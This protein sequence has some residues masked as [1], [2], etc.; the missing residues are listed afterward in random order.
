MKAHEE[1][2]IQGIKTN[3][4]KNIDVVLK[5]RSIN[6]VV[7]PSGSGK[8]SLAFDTIGGIGQHEMTSMF[9][10]EVAEP[11]YRVRS[12]RNMIAAVPIPQLNNNNNIRST[13]GTYFG[14]NRS[15][16]LLYSALLHLDEDFFVLNREQNVCPQCRGLGI[17]LQ[18]DANRVINYDTP[19]EACPIKCW[20]R[21]RDFYSQILRLFCVDQ[22]IDFKKTFRMLNDNE[23]RTIL[24]GQSEEKYSVRYKRA[25]IFST[26]S[27]HYY[28]VM[29]GKPML[30]KFAPARQFFADQPCQSCKGRK[31]SQEHE[32]FKLYELSIGEFMCTPFSDLNSWIEAVSRDAS[33]SNLSFAASHIARFVRTAVEMDLGHLFFHRSIPTLSGGEMQRLRLVQVFNTQLTDLLIVLDEPLAGLSGCERPAVYENI[34]RLADRHTLLIVDHHDTFCK[35]A[36]VIMALGEGGGKNGGSLI[37]ARRYLHAQDTAVD[38]APSKITAHLTVKLSGHV[39]GFTGVDIDL[40]KNCLNLISGKSGVGKSVLLR[41]YLPQAFEHYEYISQKALAGKKDSSVAT[42]LGIAEHIINGYARRHGKPRRFFSKLP[43]CEG[44]CPYCSGVGYV[45]VG[46]EYRLQAQIECRECAGTGFNKRLRKFT[47]LNKSIVDI[48]LMTVDEAKVFYDEAD[49]KISKVLS[50]ASEIMLGHLT[51]GQPTSTLSGGENVRIKTLKAAFS[52]GSVFGID[53]PFKGLA[54]AEMCNVIQFLNKLVKTDK[55]IIVADHE[56][57]SFRYFAKHV[58][59]SNEGGKL[60]GTTVVERVAH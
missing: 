39:Y 50:E 30:R 7:G 8:S 44:A 38:C 21:N 2:E 24:F 13:I 52:T 37:D 22:R 3:N 45:D 46:S 16:S 43:G 48:W 51:I 49:K 31:F 32:E 9:A 36:K 40:G 33:V 5:K 15:V 11:A 17:F 10:D 34:I 4:L 35:K 57:K 56:E 12:Y 29:S 55:T 23:K 20:T 25:G 1:I 47:V 53:E 59:L 27:T 28:G 60:V 6:L 14:I 54:P 41:E 58:R 18:L 19:L 26:R 42:V